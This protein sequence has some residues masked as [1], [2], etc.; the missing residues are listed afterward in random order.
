[1]KSFT[2]RTERRMGEFEKEGRRKKKKGSVLNEFH[3]NQP[4]H[5][6]SVSAF[7]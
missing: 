7:N 3:F 4:R 2:A 5:H 1:M 6:F